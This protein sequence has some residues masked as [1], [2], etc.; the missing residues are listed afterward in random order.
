MMIIFRARELGGNCQPR[1]AFQQCNTDKFLHKKPKKKD[2][3][4]QAQCQ[5]AIGVMYCTKM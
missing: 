1:F 3:Y 4:N 5:K 2:I